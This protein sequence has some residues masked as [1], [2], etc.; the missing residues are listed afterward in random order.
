M[1]NQENGYLL[2]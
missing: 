1:K 2:S